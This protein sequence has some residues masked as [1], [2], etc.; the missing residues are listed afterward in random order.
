MKID[1]AD[2]LSAPFT[3]PAY[4]RFSVWSESDPLAEVLLCR[5]SHLAP[6]PC[7]S[8]TKESVRNGFSL[9]TGL[10][11][12]QHDAL[13]DALASRGI[14][15]RF[16][17]AAAGMPDLCFTRDAAV[18]TPWGIVGLNPAKPHRR[19]EVDHV[20]AVLSRLGGR[21]ISRIQGGHI[22]GG[23]I[24]V[25]RPGLLIL[26]VS[27]D[28]TDEAGAAEFAAPFLR[29]GW[30]VVH[31][32]LDPHFLHLDTVFCMLDRRLALACKDVLDEDFLQAVAAR[33]IELIQVSY[34]EARNLAGNVVSLDGKTILT[35]AE[36][37]RI[38]AV[39]RG[40]GFEAVEVEISQFAA[41]GGGLH[42]LTMPLARTPRGA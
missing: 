29:D 10:A 36:Y 15:C 6:V 7:C 12:R 17:P 2:R 26:G 31:C 5:P 11:L 30:E 16:M 20:A 13:H 22:E 42:C 8:K 25:A 41:C 27:G 19:P 18:T 39:L 34:K 23:D 35:S 3:E 9:S 32:P 28:R 40:A 14:A 24:C 21:P 38:A 1:F 4:K 37:P 33:G